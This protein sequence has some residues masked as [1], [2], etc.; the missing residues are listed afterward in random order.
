MRHGSFVQITKAE[1]DRLVALEP[2][3]A[4]GAAPAGRQ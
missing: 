4:A 3:T 2:S 1:Y